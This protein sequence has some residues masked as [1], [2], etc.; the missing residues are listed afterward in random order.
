MAKVHNAWYEMGVDDGKS[1]ANSG[2]TR[3]DAQNSNDNDGYRT[4]NDN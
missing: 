1:M 2:L 4:K 3:P